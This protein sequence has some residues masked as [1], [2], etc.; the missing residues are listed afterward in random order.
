MQITFETHGWNSR[1]ISISSESLT[2]ETLD[3]APTWMHLK[4][5]GNPQFCEGGR[6]KSLNLRGRGV[7]IGGGLNSTQGLEHQTLEHQ[8][9][10][11]DAITGLQGIAI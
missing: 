10:S 1:E 6:S 4:T 11:K 5:N 2:S 9:G 3:K 7:W 8:R